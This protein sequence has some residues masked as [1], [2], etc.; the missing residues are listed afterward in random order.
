[1][2]EKWTF[3]FCPRELL[4]TSWEQEAASG[5]GGPASVK[6]IVAEET[7]TKLQTRSIF[8]ARQRVESWEDTMTALIGDKGDF[9]DKQFAEAEVADK[10][11]EQ[12]EWTVDR[13]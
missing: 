8:V 13:I 12:C 11:V 4:F 1:L 6:K 3:G 9:K 2:F 5:H 7:Q 10:V